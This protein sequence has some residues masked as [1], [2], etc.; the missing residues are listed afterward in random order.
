[1][2]ELG[3]TSRRGDGAA[4]GDKGRDVLAQEPLDA[5]DQLIPHARMSPNQRIHPH[6]HRRPDPRLG[7]AR[8]RDGVRQR[9]HRRRVRGVAGQDAG[10][11]V[12]E[13]RA[14]EGRE[15]ARARVGAAA[16]AG[17]DA[18][19]GLVVVELGLDHRARRGDFFEGGG[20]GRERGRGAVAG[21][22][23]DGWDRE[24]V[25]VDEHD[26]AVSGSDM[27]TVG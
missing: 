14:A 20:G 23:G 22:G 11:L 1:M 17:G 19:D 9:E 24:R 7:H 2:L 25:A 21:D 13:E 4:Q 15:V 27:S 16:E 3:L 6:E 10:V 8:R 26:F 12:L 18:V 5:L